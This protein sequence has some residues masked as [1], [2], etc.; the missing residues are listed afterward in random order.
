MFLLLHTDILRLRQWARSAPT[1]LSDSLL[2]FP[3]HARKHDSIDL[4]AQDAL[5][6]NSSE[7]V[8]KTVSQ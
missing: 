2:F 3:E 7:F 8:R 4:P 5:S 1:S 6:K